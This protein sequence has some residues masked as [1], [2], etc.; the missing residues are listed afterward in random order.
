VPPQGG[1]A[2]F[3]ALLPLSLDDL[4]VTSGALTLMSDVT[5]PPNSYAISFKGSG[6]ATSFDGAT[7]DVTK[8]TI[9]SISAR[10]MD[11][12][13]IIQASDLNLGAKTLSNLIDAGDLLPLLNYIMQTND[14]VEGS[15]Y[16]NILA[17]MAGRDTIVGLACNDSLIGFDGSDRMVGA[18][19]I[20]TLVV[21]T[22]PTAF[23]EGPVR[24][25][26]QAKMA[27]I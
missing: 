11:G 26:W 27:G 10:N 6:F 9:R 24:T 3:L 22:R 23:M 13:V 16:D 21:G 4:K 19:Q 7:Y 12:D 2:L 25:F 1:S 14:Q 15:K 20:D 17:G 5:D 8:D 18:K